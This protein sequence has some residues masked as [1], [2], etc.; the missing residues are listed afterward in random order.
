MEDYW[1]QQYFQGVLPP[2]VLASEA[3]M[4][5]FVAQTPQAIGYLPY[6]QVDAQ[7]RVVLLIGSGGRV[8]PES[9]Q[10]V[11]SSQPPPAAADRP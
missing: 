2:H 5:R 7:L 4:Q 3:A 10:P 1:N 8:L 6:C 11:C 9:E